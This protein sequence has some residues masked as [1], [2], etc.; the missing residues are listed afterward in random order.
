MLGSQKR[1]KTSMIDSPQGTTADT[2]N[3]QCCFV[4]G[5]EAPGQRDR[6]IYRQGWDVQLMDHCFLVLQDFRCPGLFC[7]G[8]HLFFPC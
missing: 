4:Y 3:R 5:L 1:G 7:V 6:S 8:F 2:R